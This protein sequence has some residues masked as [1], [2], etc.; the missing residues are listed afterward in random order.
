MATTDVSVLSSEWGD[1]SPFLLA[2][3][4][5]VKR[6]GKS[7]WGQTESSDPVKVVAA[8]TEANMEIALNWQSPFESSGPEQQIPTLAALLQTGQIQTFFG[9]SPGGGNNFFSGF[10]GRTGITKLNSTQVFNGMPPVKI[11]VTALLRAWSDAARE[12]E[13]LH[14]KLMEWALPKRLSNDPTT[15]VR[16]VQ[17]IGSKS[18]VDMLM[19]SESPTTIGL[20]YKGKTYSPLVIESIGVPLD[21]PIDRNGRYVSMSIPMTLCTLT[22][23]DRTDWSGKTTGLK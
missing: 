20:T 8:L 17:G 15:L 16:L 7:D 9:Q 22:A 21:S 23:I 11:T 13:R 14:N 12:V 2:K 10:E 4:Y 1:L 6:I 5:E 3:F 18:A 19:P